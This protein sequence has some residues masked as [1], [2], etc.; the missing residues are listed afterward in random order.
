VHVFEG[1]AE[2]IADRRRRVREL[3]LSD[4]SIRQIAEKTGV[5]QP[6][7]QN[8]INQMGGLKALRGPLSNP[9]LQTV[10]ALDEREKLLMA[11]LEKLTA[12]RKALIEAKALKLLSCFDGKGVLIRKESSSLGLSLDD[13]YELVDRLTAYL[14][15]LGSGS[16]E[17]SD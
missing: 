2:E 11:Q 7:I 15:A 5:A 9:S 13:A 6:T 17:V 3:L 12:D 8:D 16:A 14:S 1:S 10:E 4:L